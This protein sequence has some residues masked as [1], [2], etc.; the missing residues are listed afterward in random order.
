MKFKSLNYWSVARSVTVFV[1]FLNLFATASLLHAAAIVPPAIIQQ[2]ANAIASTNEDISFSVTTTGSPSSFQWL[3]NG[4]PLNLQT[5]ASLLLTNLALTES[6]TFAVIVSNAAGTATSSNAVLSVQ[7]NI[8]RRLGTGRIVQIDS[9]VGV[10][11][12]F[13]SNGRESSIS[14]SLNYAVDVYSNPEFSAGNPNAVVTVD[15]THPGSIGIALTLPNRQTFPAGYQSAGL[16]RFDLT[17]GR[18]SL[19]AGLSF[20]TVPIPIAAANT[21]GQI[22]NL[23]AN[24]LPQMIPATAAPI[25]NPQSGLF[26]HRLAV[27]NP[28]ST[29]MTNIDILALNPGV[30]LASNAITFFNAQ[31]TQTNLPYGDPLIG[32]PCNCP[33]PGGAAGLDEYLI[34]GNSNCSI[35]YSSTNST[36]S[37]SQ[38]NNLLPGESRTIS[39]E[40]Y[41]IDHRTAPAP[42]YSVFLTD[43]FTRVLPGTVLTTLSIDRS[44]Y[45]SNAFLVEFPTVLGKQYYIQYA[46]AP[47]GFATGQIVF[48]PVI[49]T[50]SRVQWIDNGPPK[51]ISP[52]VNGSRFY[53][54]LSDQ[55]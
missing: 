45:L 34:C 47:A 44:L 36:F 1:V 27:S 26:E 49:G 19:E 22:L 53:R 33:L 15:T 17:A 28:G 37:F 38:L 30:D 2:P 8:A 40:Y 10:P 4:A 41:V 48:P 50:G 5:N 16:I 3:F 31:G 6:G 9:K 42:Q 18:D 46:P 52:P 12:T 35:D 23:S 54:V 51:T 7:T 13:R 14:F 25:L 20:S 39:I 32:I 29:T 11:I 21:N 24:V 55:P 43:P